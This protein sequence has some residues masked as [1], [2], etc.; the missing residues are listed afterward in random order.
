M[1]GDGEQN[2]FDISIYR[3]FDISIYRNFR[4]DIYPTLVLVFVGPCAYFWNVR[5]VLGWRLG[6]RSSSRSKLSYR[7]VNVTPPSADFPVLDILTVGILRVPNRPALEASRR[8]LSEDASFGIG[9]LLVV[10]QTSLEKPPQ[11]GDV[12]VH[13][14]PSCMAVLY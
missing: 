6:P 1:P 4:Y 12:Y 5:T 3:N 8:E 9:T 11:G 14:T 10:E 13:V 7:T 2:T